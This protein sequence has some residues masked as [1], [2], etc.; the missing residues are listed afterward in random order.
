MIVIDSSAAI[1]VFRQEHDAEIYARSI[2]AD[3]DP[4][5]SAANLVEPSIVL[6]GL[7]EIT[8]SRSW[9]CSRVLPAVSAIPGRAQTRARNPSGR[10]LRSQWIPGS[11]LR[12][13]LRCAIAHRGMTTEDQSVSVIASEAKQS[14]PRHTG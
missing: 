5:M 9:G 11:M 1:A 13:A 10:I 14:I 12:I 4:I 2:A 3:N 7:K 6:R 8:P